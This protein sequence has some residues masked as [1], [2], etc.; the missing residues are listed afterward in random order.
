[1]AACGK[2]ETTTLWLE[3]GLQ[4][5]FSTCNTGYFLHLFCT[6]VTASVFWGRGVGCGSVTVH[7]SGWEALANHCKLA[8]ELTCVLGRPSGQQ[9]QRGGHT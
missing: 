3:E 5:C 8:T 4:F 9:K 7:L 2:T 1:M 6:I